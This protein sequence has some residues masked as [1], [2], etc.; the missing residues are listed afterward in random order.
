MNSGPNGWSDFAAGKWTNWLDGL[1][2][3]WSDPWRRA[4]TSSTPFEV[5]M[6]PLSAVDDGGKS[7]HHLNAA[8]LGATAIK[9]RAPERT[10]EVLRVI[11]YLVAPFGSNE[12]L[13]LSYGVEGPDYAL[14]ERGNPELTERGN[15]DANYLPFKYIA[16]RPSVLYL[17]DIPD[18]TRVLSEAE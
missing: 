8:H 6:I 7:V 3:A 2:T 16:Q 9:K 4:R 1:A 5:H 14:D 15:P 10:R 17:P 18:Y 13:V 11:N 12:D